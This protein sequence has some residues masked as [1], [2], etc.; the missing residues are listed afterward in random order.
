VFT[1]ALG[2]G[3]NPAPI[4]GI[5][6]SSK[7]NRPTFRATGIGNPASFGESFADDAADSRDG[8]RLNGNLD[9]GEGCGELVDAGVERPGHLRVHV[10]LRIGTTVPTADSG[11]LVGECLQPVLHGL[12]S[13]GLEVDRDGPGLD[14]LSQA[15]F[16]ITDL[17]L[18]PI[19]DP[20]FNSNSANVFYVAHRSPR[21]G[22]T[23]GSSPW[24]ASRSLRFTSM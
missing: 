21:F 17:T 6:R 23:S 22:Y 2:Q 7:S 1:T 10:V 24:R 14:Q 11:H 16:N 12:E 9:V 13:M 18:G 19:S 4:S 8:F 20:E 5:I 15:L 3:I